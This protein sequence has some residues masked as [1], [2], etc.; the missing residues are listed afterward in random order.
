[1]ECQLMKRWLSAVVLIVATLAADVADAADYFARTALAGTNWNAANM[2]SNTSCAAGGPVAGPPT[3]ADNVIICNGKAVTVNIATAN[4]G[5]IRIDGGNLATS[6]TIAGTNVLNVTNA[7]GS[8]GNV[9]INAS[10]AAITKQIAVNTGTLN[11]TGS[12]TIN[13]GTTTANNNN[14]AQLRVTTGSA[15]IGSLVVTGGTVNSIARAIVDGAAGSLTVNGNASIATGTLGRGEMRIT[16][17]GTGTITVNGSLG[18]SSATSTNNS[19]DATVSVD[20]VAGLLNV[21]GDVT[22]TGSAGATDRDALLSITAGSNAN[23][24]ITIGGALNITSG[25]AGSASVT[26]AGGAGATLS[27]M[28]VGGNINNGDLLTVATGTLTML[29]VGGTNTLTTTNAAAINATT[30]VTTGTINAHNATVDAGAGALG[31]KRMNLNGAGTINVAGNLSISSATSAGS[32]ATVDVTNVDGLLNVTGNVTV[33]G[34]AAT[35]RNALLSITAG[36]NANRGITIGGALNITSTFAGTASVTMAGGAGATLS[37]MTVGGN[38]NNGDV[39]TVATGTLT[40]L[41]LGGT[42]NTLTTT[43]AAPIN[44]TTSVTTGTINAH[45]ATVDAG[46]GALGLKRMNVGGTGTINV[47]GNLSITSATSTGSDATV[48]VTNIGGL[49]NVTGNV[50][51]TGAAATGLNALLNVSAGS[52]AG[53]G[54]TIGGTL[55]ITST[56]ATTAAV[57]MSGGVSPN[58]SSMTVGGNINNGDTLTVTTGTLSMLPLGGTTNT[59]TTTNAANIA[60]ITSVTNGTINA[61]NATVNSGIGATA[62][63]RMNLNG[64]GTINV[65]GNLIVTAATSTGGDATVNVT[66]AGGLLNVTGNTTITGGGAADRDALLSIT[67]ASNVGRGI[68]IGGT[69][70]INTTVAGSSSVT[71]AA[72]GLLTVTGAMT[73]NDT[74]TLST[75]GTVNANGGFTN[76]GVFTNTLGGQLFLR[77]TANVINGTFTRGSGTVTMNGSALQNLSGT[78]LTPPTT[79]GAGFNNLVINNAA[80]VR[81]GA[82]TVTVKGILTLTSGEVDANTNGS[83][84]I[85]E[86]LCATAV[87]R[88]LAGGHVVGRLQKN[89][90]ALASNCTYEVGIA[91]EYMPVALAHDAAATAGRMIA[92]VTSGD[93]PNIATSGLDSAKSVNRWWTLTTTGVVGAAS[94]NPGTYGATFTFVN[95]NSFDA[96][97]APANFEAERWNGATWAVTTA[98]VRTATTTPVTGLTALGQFAVAEKKVVVP[99][100]G[101]FN[102]FEPPPGTAITGN[103]KTKISGSAFSLAVV[104]I[105]GAGTAQLTTFTDTVL[106]DLVGNNTLGVPLDG[107]NCPTTFSDLPDVS[108]NP[109]LT[110]GVA[111]VNFAAVPDSWRDVRVRM[112][113]PAAGPFTVTSCSTNNFAIRPDAFT[114]LAFSNDTR[115]TAGTT[116]P[117]NSTTFGSVLHNAGQPFSVRASA[118]NAAGSPV[119]TANYAGAP[120]ATLTACGGAACTA[121]QGTLSLTTTFVSG[122]LSSDTVAYNDVGSFNLQLIDDTFASVDGADSTPAERQILSAVVPVGRFVPDHFVVVTQNVPVFAPACTGFTYQGQLF[123]YSTPPAITLSARAADGTTTTT[124]YTGTWW[125][126]T[127]ASLTPGTQ[128][129]R[130]AAA[131]GTLDTTALPA[132]ETDPVILDGGGGNGSLTFSSGSGTGSGLRFTRNNSTPAAELNAEIALSI[133]VIDADGVS[134]AS[135][136]VAF[137]AASANNGILFS[138]GNALNGNDKRVRYGRLRLS[139][140]SGSQLLAMRIPVEAQYWNGSVFV[141]NTLDSCTTLSSANVGLGNFGG[142]LSVGETSASI[143]NSPL[144]SGRSAIQLTKP[145]AANSG[146]VDVTVNLGVVDLDLVPGPPVVPNN[147]ADAC[148]AFAPTAAGSDNTHLR[149]AWCAPG[150]YTKDPSARVRFGINRGSD[151]SIYRREQ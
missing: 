140:V 88:P 63:K 112:R 42:T 1:M 57:T 29:P 24:G 138:D 74:V 14:I 62:L 20:N 119:V 61:H 27:K 134:Y 78:A 32:D 11:V 33:T 144:Q 133:N 105:N 69:L 23:R 131:S 40:M 130:Y 143:V 118:V 149:G 22:V 137:G 151:Q 142:N 84:M 147:N 115:T 39:L 53:R 102:A 16:N 25:F 113:W 92:S 93:H 110:S 15:S 18:V 45:N 43:N 116:N 141:T 103:I 26:M 71:L 5:S 111:T 80:G 77:G 52:N 150:T 31:L 83:M 46:A 19:A 97:A 72:A 3:A 59:L 35:G 136:P 48:D 94:G 2:W 121:T 82:G 38:I 100:P 9:L 17:L 73:N 98:G 107:N 64:T 87:S 86:T 41:P 148:N 47:A 114:G 108:P 145:G 128:G 139:G 50:T 126:L 117:L 79:A 120:V 109:T 10:T 65:A 125:R 67:T 132:V 55:N 91:G 8:T 68:T 85:T 7:S 21:T 95:P 96:G 54:V 44:A 99:T 124:R 37:K 135:N 66:N 70:D 76:S 146:S 51:V 28:T 75:T 49:L 81:L 123:N 30:S 58:F 106:V 12:V 6:L 104:A 36:S 34:A 101:R 90:P 122:L 56:F 127:N 89:I 129:A 60:V 13:G 4:A